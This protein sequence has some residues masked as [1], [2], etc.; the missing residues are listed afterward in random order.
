MS[1]LA[2]RHPIGSWWR[3]E[4]GQIAEVTGY[5]TLW[6]GEYVELLREPTHNGPASPVPGLKP[7]YGYPRKKRPERTLTV[8]RTE[9]LRPV[10]GSEGPTARYLAQCELLHP[11]G[12]PIM[13]W[14]E[15]PPR[16]GEQLRLGGMRGG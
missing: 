11:D 4:T 1:A 5:R 15:T 6:D 7:G 9:N 13:E 14:P 12:V 10:A 3:L 8:A 2:T 16:G